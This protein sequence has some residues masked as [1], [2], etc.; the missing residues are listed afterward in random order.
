M[1]YDDIL[2]QQ[3]DA[4]W[5]WGALVLDKPNWYTKPT[6]MVEEMFSHGERQKS[7]Y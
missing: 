6:A 7:H 4:F 1:E 2:N 3:F 5:I